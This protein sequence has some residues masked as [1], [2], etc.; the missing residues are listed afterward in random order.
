[1]LRLLDAMCLANGLTDAFALEARPS[2][3]TYNP[4]TAAQWNAAKEAQKANKQITVEAMA[5]MSDAARSEAE[6]KMLGASA[7]N[8]TPGVCVCM[9]GGRGW[10]VGGLKLLP[11]GCFG[12]FGCLLFVFR[13][14]LVWFARKGRR[15]ARARVDDT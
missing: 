12:F 13:F 9:G 3:A 14:G 2:S 7:M 8:I 11:C 1:M 10:C 4:I 15:V 5:E 6:A